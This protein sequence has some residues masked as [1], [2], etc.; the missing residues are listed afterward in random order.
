MLQRIARSILSMVRSTGSLIAATLGTAL[1]TN[2]T[3]SDQYL[4]LVLTGRMYKQA[5]DDYDLAPRNL[6]RALEDSGTLTS[7]LI[8][9][10]TCGAYMAVA[11]GVPTIAY[12][13]YAVLNYTI[14]LI[15]L[16]YGFLGWTI[17]KKAA[18]R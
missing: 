13:P 17:V 15:S 12:L 14:P 9:W 16:A 3:A 1:F 4:S 7:A 18:D 10:N 2:V 6:S 11:L 8:P 5:Y